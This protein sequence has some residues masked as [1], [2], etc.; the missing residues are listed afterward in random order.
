MLQDHVNGKDLGTSELDG[1]AVQSPNTPQNTSRK[2]ELQKRATWTNWTTILYLAN[3]CDQAKSSCDWTGVRGRIDLHTARK[4]PEKLKKRENKEENE[5]EVEREEQRLEHLEF[6]R[7]F[8][9]F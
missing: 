3:L 9:Y 8:S 1:A 2:L 5:K 7:A 4:L 6:F